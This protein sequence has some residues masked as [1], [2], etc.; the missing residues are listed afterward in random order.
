[1][2]ELP[3]QRNSKR[4]RGR[5]HAPRG[6]QVEHPHYSSDFRNSLPPHGSHR[7]RGGAPGRDRGSNQRQGIKYLSQT[8]VKALA[9]SSSAEV[10]ACVNDNEAGFLAAFKHERYCKNPLMMKHLIKLLYLLVK[11]DDFDRIA[12]RTLARILSADGSYALFIMKLDFLVK[13]MIDESRDYVK[14]ENPQYLNYLIE[15][16]HKAIKVIPETVLNTYPLLVVQKTIQELIKKGES[17]DTLEQKAKKLEL[18]FKF[19]QE[20]RSKKAAVVPEAVATDSVEPPE[21]FVHVEILPSLSEVQSSDEKVYLRRNLVKGSYNNWDHYLDVQYRLLR[22]DFVRPLRHGIQHYCTPG[23]AKTSLDIRIYERVHV[24]NPVCLFTG[25]GFEIQFDITKLKRVN[26]EHSRRLIFGSLLCLSTD[27]FE[28]SMLFATVV[29]RD[30]DLLKEGRLIVKFEGDFNEF[31]INPD[32]VFTMVESTAY[33]EAYRHILDKLKEISAL[34]DEIPFKSYIT[35]LRISDVQAPSYSSNQ[36]RIRFDLSHI[37]GVASRVFLYDESSWPQA[38]ATTLDS[39]QLEALKM[40]LT[41][42]IS[43]IQGPPGTGKTF[44]GLKIVE[45]FLQNRPVW[46]RNREAPILVVCY[47]NHALDQFLEGIQ[48]I[49]IENQTPNIIRIGGRCKSEKLADYILRKKVSEC[50]AGNDL[51]R[52]L[53]RRLGESRSAMLKGKDLLHKMLKSSSSCVD[54]TIMQLMD[55]EPVIQLQHYKQL[56]EGYR[57]VPGREL[58]V[59][60]DVWTP[61]LSDNAAFEKEEELAPSSSSEPDNYIHVDN[62]AKLIEEDRILEGEEVELLAS[63]G[64]ETEMLRFPLQNQAGENQWKTVEVKS[65][66]KPVEDVLSNP[67]SAEEASNISDV[68]KLPLHKKWQLYNYWKQEYAQLCQKQ[69]KECAERYEQACENYSDCS[70]RID[71]HVLRGCDVI[72]I[73]TTGAAKHH[74]VLR[75]MHPKVVIFEEAAEIFEAH[76][77]TSLAPSVQQLVLIGDHKQL[78]PKPNCYDL[79]VKYNLSVSLF[80]RLIRNKIPYVTL[81]V[82]HRMRPEISSLIHPSIYNHLEDHASVMRRDHVEGVAKDVF[83]VDHTQP[84]RSNKESEVTTHVNEFEADYLVGLCRYLLSQHDHH[85]HHVQGTAS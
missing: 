65:A 62:E 16:G 39:S 58:E 44:I 1:M 25:I 29:K 79:E 42:E 55:L 19:A 57:S 80:E 33:F 14:R 18:A 72:G 20:E 26:W 37:V 83:F 68:W 51:P 49:F 3:Q 4:G 43:V 5:N 10:V 64:H 47:T 22:E 85:S 52:V 84:E 48:N 34:S 59:W 27:K 13:E 31:Q 54:K 7:G 53:M 50:Q 66:K 69:I 38:E 24:L 6:M 28:Q 23:L 21:H 60:L 67:L 70:K 30:V 61:E 73:T 75:K 9:Q 76:I 46:D 63:L 17:L 45:A 15:I 77:V 2:S 74:H 81:T 82:Q 41:K 12:P 40:A 56:C 32:Q 11:S 8:D 35:G 78:Q 71:E 36:K